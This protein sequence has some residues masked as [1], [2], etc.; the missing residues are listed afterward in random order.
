MELTRKTGVVFWLLWHGIMLLGLVLIP[1][2]LIFEEPA[3]SLS[4]N[5]S[6]F[7][8]GIALAY[9]A[10]LLILTI[11]SGNHKAVSP[12]D[13]LLVILAVF[14]VYFLV[15]LLTGSY[16]SRPILLFAF[17]SAVLLFLVSFSFKLAFQK[18]L[19]F[20]AIPLVFLSQVMADDIV[21]L[22]KGGVPGPQFSQ[23]LIGTEFYD[24]RASIYKNLIDGCPKAVERCGPS[25][26]NGGGISTF[27]DGYLLATGE[28]DLFYLLPQ[29]DSDELE[30]SHL[31]T[32]I[33]INTDSFQAD[34]GEADVWLYRVTDILVQEKADGFRLFAAYHYW[35][36]D[37][38]CSVLRISSTEGGYAGFLAGSGDAEWQ[39]VYDS[40]PCLPVTKGRR[41]DR[42]KGADSGGRMVLLDDGRLLFTVGDYQVDGWNRE[43][44]LAQN[45]DVPYGKTMLIDLDGGEATV[46]S[47]GHRN[48]QGMYADDNGDI[49]LTEHGPRGGDE[50][51]LVLEGRN[52]GWPWVTYG[53]EYGE[54]KWPLS[55]HQGRHDGYQ[56]PVYSWIPSIA[57]SSVIG[58]QHDMFPLWQGDLLVASY[59]ESLRRLRVR[60]GRVIYQEPI[61]VLKRSGRIRDLMEDK[62]GRIV[63][64]FDGGSIA[65]LEPLDEEMAGEDVRGQVLYVQCAGCHNVK[66]GG[67]HPRDSK[68]PGIGPDLLGI[69]GRKIAG[70][71]EYNYSSALQK[72]SGTWSDE[73]LGKFLKD[74]QGFAP[75]N[76]ME[77]PG[78]QD[79]ADRK[80]VVEYLSTLK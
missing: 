57:V 34:N 73:N 47:S 42:F 10:C 54:K 53:T 52:Y 14:G 49:W 31:K 28:G 12:G 61:M 67:G 24:V 25:A 35:D 17:I 26:T 30:S 5:E 69:A 46:Y 37:R 11:M 80:K 51:N 50:L 59:K 23:T 66:T 65:V 78:I 75:G 32:R 3:W 16:F 40:E 48:Q 18:L 62:D 72:L 43:E 22:L 60:E 29:A 58:V 9:L 19:L 56:R 79:D 68:I 55:K 13:L 2:L 44:I 71:P 15:L 7:L 45:K 36:S 41:G 21:K 74:P 76:K 63:L 39:T 77:F 8:A 27:D 70:V 20:I 6:T 1:G 38:H 64:W 33:P 4:S